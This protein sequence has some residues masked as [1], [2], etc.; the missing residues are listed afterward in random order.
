MRRTYVW[1]LDDTLMDNT[2]DYAKPILDACWLI[3]KTL[4]CRAPHVTEIINMEHEIDRRRVKEINP[5]TGNPFLYSMKRFPGSQVETYREICRKVGIKPETDVEKKLY[6]LGLRAFDKKRYLKDIKSEA[7]P[8][9][10]FLADQKDVSLLLTKGDNWVQKKKIA[11]LKT[12]GLLDY[13]SQVRIV[14][15]KTPDDF[16][17]F[18]KGYD[19]NNLYSVGNSYGSDIIPALKAGFRGIFIPVDTWETAGEMEQIISKVD[20]SRC[21]VLKNLSEIKDKY[22]EMK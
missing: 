2:H 20:K 3:V 15:D 19:G 8:V 10:K 21:W 14:D 7:L 11:V 9:L 16:E 4:G 1:D 18:A 22:K 13:F 12:A 6:S 5:K 17:L